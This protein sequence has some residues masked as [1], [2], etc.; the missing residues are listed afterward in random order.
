MRI[1][2]DHQVFSLQDVGG[3]S[4]YYF[5]LAK[6]IAGFDSCSIEFF[7]GMQ[8]NIFRFADP[9]RVKT[10]GYSGKF[11]IPPGKLRYLLNELLSDLCLPTKGQFDIYH[12]THSRHLSVVRKRKMVVT[13]HDCAYEKYP[14]LFSSAVSVIAMRRCLF[15]HADAIICISAATRR[16]LHHFYDVPESKTFVVHYGISQ[17]KPITTNAPLLARPFLLCVGSRFSFKN[18]DGLLRSFS[19][20]ELSPDYDLLV[21]GG[22]P[23][24]SLETALIQELGI[25]RN[26][27]FM[28]A[29]SDA[30]LA[31][32]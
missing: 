15:D 12:P 20:V 13:H 29:V 10:L 4:R 11:V 1:L 7:L 5:E 26:V 22:G 9:P 25:G 2:Y 19:Q 18:F 17:I 27:H 14:H 30:L 21:L 24:T 8:R 31:Q 23:P 3:I 16:D 32:A 28:P 6:H